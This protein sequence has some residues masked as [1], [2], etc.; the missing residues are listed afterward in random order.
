MNTVSAKLSDEVCGNQNEKPGTLG[1]GNKPI[2][3]R[4]S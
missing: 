2:I 4:E 3:L 1:G